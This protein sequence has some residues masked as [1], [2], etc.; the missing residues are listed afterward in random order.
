[1][2][3][4]L[5]E[6]GRDLMLRAMISMAAADGQVDDV[7]SATVS[8]I[9]EQVA[10]ETVA[11]TAIA[12]VAADIKR[13]DRTLTKALEAA[14]GDLDGFAK[15]GIVRAAYL[16]LVADGKVATP[17]RTRLVNIGQ[18]LGMPEGDIDAILEGGSG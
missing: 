13:G 11:D 5:S 2:S 7:E 3:S 14:A 15:D 18:A 12:D 10:G 8:A 4:K 17:E 6:T 1:M 9:F 16:V